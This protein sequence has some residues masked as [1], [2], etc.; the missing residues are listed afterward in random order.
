MNKAPP[1][2]AKSGSLINSPHFGGG[3]GVSRQPTFDAE[4]KNAKIQISIFKGGGGGGVS[5][6][7]TFDA[8]SKNAKIQISIFFWGGGQLPANFWC[9][10]QK[11]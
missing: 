9:W 10:V 2:G 6:R 5:C 11:C 8:E 1:V 4:S 3:G 7:P